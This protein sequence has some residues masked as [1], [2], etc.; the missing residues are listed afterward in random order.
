[1][2]PTYLADHADALPGSLMDVLRPEERRDVLARMTASPRWAEA[3]AHLVAAL[4]VRAS[5]ELR[6][7]AIELLG[8]LEPAVRARALAPVLAR[9]PASRS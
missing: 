4:S 8:D 5:K 2:L 1:M 6:R 9:A 3:G 7:Q